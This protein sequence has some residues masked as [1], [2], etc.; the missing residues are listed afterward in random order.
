MVRLSNAQQLVLVCLAAKLRLSYMTLAL[1]L[2]YM[3][4]QA[5]MDQPVIAADGH[6]YEK[7]AKQDWLLQH[8]AS[9]V[10]ML[11][12]SNARLV[13]NLAIKSIISSTGVR[14]MMS[15]SPI[16]HCCMQS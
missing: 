1:Q 4:M 16:E 8:Q 7:S 3:S 13:P 12:L 15:A 2:A 9:P 14:T 11:A 5:V 10:T 6:T